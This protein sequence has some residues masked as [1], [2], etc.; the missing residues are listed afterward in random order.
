MYL[1]PDTPG[2]WRTFALAPVNK[3]VTVHIAFDGPVTDEAIKKAIRILEMGLDW[4]PPETQKGFGDSDPLEVEILS[5]STPSGA[6]P[7]QM[8]AIGETGGGQ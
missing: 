4:A 3:T 7:D 1:M 5:A 6:N 8:P 2:K